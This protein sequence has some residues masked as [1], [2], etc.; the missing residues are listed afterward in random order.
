MTIRGDSELLF[1]FYLLYILRLLP[2]F[3]ASLKLS[4][5]Y[6]KDATRFEAKH[7]VIFC[8]IGW[9]RTETGSNQRKRQ[10]ESDHCI[11]MVSVWTSGPWVFCCDLFDRGSR[12]VKCDPVNR[13]RKNYDITLRWRIL[14][15]S[16]LG[17]LYIATLT[18]LQMCTNLRHFQDAS[19]WPVWNNEIQNAK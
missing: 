4:V 5:P 3:L 18:K 13:V 17:L 16:A 8:K 15:V 7:D 9:N 11:S 12:Q 1:I 19:Y 6:E 10:F 2:I 14:H